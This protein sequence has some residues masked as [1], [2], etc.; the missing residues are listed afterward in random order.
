MYGCSHVECHCG[1]HFCYGCLEP[2]TECDGQCEEAE[3]DENNFDEDDLDEDDLDGRA[4]YYDGDGRELGGEPR[5]NM[6][7]IWGCIHHWNLAKRESTSV[8]LHGQQL[9]CQSCFQAV[10]FADEVTKSLKSYHKEQP[11]EVMDGEDVVMSGTD[12]AHSQLEKQKWKCYCG[13]QTCAT[14]LREPPHERA[15]DT[16]WKWRCACGTTCYRC[17]RSAAKATANIDL[18][19][20]W[21]CVCGKIICGACKEN[22]SE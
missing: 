8:M 20:G 13:H 19:V 5:D 22:D 1:A 11:S 21:E 6:A 7:D 4:G 18:T 2:F 10:Q 3:E 12:E 14:C 15:F 9:T 16:S 17:D